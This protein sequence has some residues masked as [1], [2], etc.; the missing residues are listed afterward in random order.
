MKKSAL[1]AFAT[2]KQGITWFLISFLDY[3]ATSCPPVQLP[4][5]LLPLPAD[6]AA[7]FVMLRFVIVQFEAVANPEPNLVSVDAGLLKLGTFFL[8]LRDG[9]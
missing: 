2:S 9:D 1:E 5:S 6:S 7:I 4:F 3:R 8:A